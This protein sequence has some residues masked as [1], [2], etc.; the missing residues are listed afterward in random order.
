MGA[1]V[2][3]RY[4]PAKPHS[5]CLIYAQ[6]WNLEQNMLFILGVNILYDI[7]INMA[8]YPIIHTM[9]VV[10]EDGSEEECVQCLWAQSLLFYQ[11]YVWCC[12]S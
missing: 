9:E 7:N 3:G 10:V 1:Q 12:A 4:L 2:P 6:A 5:P 11:Y 8:L